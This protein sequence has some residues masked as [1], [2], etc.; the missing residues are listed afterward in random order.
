MIKSLLRDKMKWLLSAL[1]VL[2]AALSLADQSFPPPNPNAVAVSQTVVDRKGELLR[3]FAVD[4]GRWRLA[5]KLSEVDP[6]L[7]RMIIA[8]EDKRFYG[9]VGVDGVALGRAAKQLITTGHIVSGG[10]TITMQVARLL[11]PRETRSLAAKLKQI[12]RAVQLERRYSKDEILEFYFTLAPYGGNLEGVRAASLSWFGK[13]PRKL[14]VAE[15]ALLVALPQSP[16]A[17]RPDRFPLRVLAARNRVLVRMQ[18][19]GV[20]AAED[21]GLA[22]AEPLP[23]LRIDLPALAAH[24]SNTAHARKIIQLTIDGQKQRDVERMMRAAAKT[25]DPSLSMAVLVVDV[26]NGEVLARA[27]SSKPFDQLSKGWVDMTRAVRSPGSTLKPFIYGLAF[28]NGIALPETLIE[29]RAENFRGYQP[30]NFAQ[31]FHGT[32]TLREALQQSLNLPAVQLLDAV[33]P[34]RLASTFREAGIAIKLPRNASPTLAVALGGVGLTLEDLVT[35]YSAFPRGGVPFMLHEQPSQNQRE[36]G[37][38]PEL[39][40]ANASWYVTDIL[41]GTAPPEGVAPLPISYKTGTSYGYRDAWAL[42]FDSN[43]VVGVWVGRAD[44][45]AVAEL[46]GRKA[47]APLLFN[48]FAALKSMPKKILPPKTVILTAQA[49]PNTLKHFGAIKQSAEQSHRSLQIMFP[50]EG[51]KLTRAVDPAGTF[52]PMVMRVEGGQAPY[53]VLLNG[54]P[55]EGQFRSS[56]LDIDTNAAGFSSVTVIDARGQVA[57]VN[58]FLN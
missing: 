35:L 40:G 14:S 54:A 10:S 2:I 33:G 34:L 22:L 25:L 21:M 51:A 53:R 11:E 55:A 19:A 29:D 9:H 41:A 56:A 32:V 31:N 5:V 20:I 23:T 58:V 48:V 52:R 18:H 50:P 27:G 15:A 26:H 43:F 1:V 39:F 28:E 37:A 38:A 4:G 16:E 24:E 49:L 45:T 36:A 30:K 3:P 42:G 17:R 7:Q 46:T 47:A 57:T 13:E 44:G 12:A 6:L 8:Y